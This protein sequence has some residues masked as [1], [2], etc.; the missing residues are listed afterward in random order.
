M[1]MKVAGSLQMLG[2]CVNYTQSHTRKL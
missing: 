2:Q 1:M